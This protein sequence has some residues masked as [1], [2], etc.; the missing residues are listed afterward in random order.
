MISI[1]TFNGEVPRA[2][3]HLLPDNAAQSATDCDF[4]TV[5]LTG[6]PDYVFRQTTAAT[7][8]KSAFCYANSD[9]G[10][11]NVRY[12][13]WQQDA[14]VVRGPVADDAYDRMYW[15]AAPDYRIKVTRDSTLGSSS[16]PDPAKTYWAGVPAPEFAPTANT[17]SMTYGGSSVTDVVAICETATG[18]VLSSTSI[19]STAYNATYLTESA[20]EISLSFDYSALCRV[21]PSGGIGAG[22]SLPT[23]MVLSGVSPTY[24]A[25]PTYNGLVTTYEQIGV[26][27]TSTPVNTYATSGTPIPL[28]TYKKGG[29]DFVRYDDWL[30]APLGNTLYVPTT[31]EYRVQTGQEYGPY[32]GDNG[33]GYAPTYGQATLVTGFKTLYDIG[34]G[35]YATD[36][37]AVSP[38]GLSSAA[39]LAI[40]VYFGSNVITLREN[41]TRSTFGLSGYTGYFQYSPGKLSIFINATGSS[42]MVEQRV[43]AYTYVN[44]FGEEGPL[45]PPLEL[46]VNEGH[47][48]AVTVQGLAAT[49]YAPINK[50]RLYRSATG[51]TTTTLLFVEEFENAVS[52]TYTD[53]KPAAV[54]GEENRT[55]TYF[56][57]EADLRGLIA[58]PNG[59]L[60][61]FK[62]NEVHVSEP[63]LPFA[64]NPENIIPT[65]ETVVSVCAAEGGFYITT[66]GHPYFVSGV[67]PDAMSS[68]KLDAVQAG[69]SKGS[70][71]NIGPAV[72]WASNDGIVFARGG[73]ASMD[74]SFN[75]FT[76]KV[77]RDLYEQRLH[78]M[79]FSAH[80][81]HLVVW[82]EDGYPGFLVK[83]DETQPSM[84]KLLRGFY[85]AAVDPRR[86][87]LLVSLNG[88]D[89]HGF[90]AGSGSAFVWH[91]KDFVAPKP[92]N[93]GAVQIVGDGAATVHCYADGVLRQSKTVTFDKK[94]TVYRLPSGFLARRWSFKIEGSGVI[95]EFNAAISPGEFAGV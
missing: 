64:W 55:S 92:T 7:S 18:T 29:V 73:S 25:V 81:G 40:Q 16:E 36:A 11:L 27:S 41:A 48:V 83:F 54:L 57:P 13:A 76:R 45:S 93:L 87:E 21:R 20:S 91:S 89:L 47:S 12:Y 80:D 30:D 4:T 6:L 60:V 85:A 62:G 43:Y 95:D 49:D 68:I 44:I 56:P 37:S 32:G 15:T 8:I 66:L 19:L 51:S 50:I 79:R 17:T 59:I 38:G 82:F 86:D 63:Y 39:T 46:P 35:W 53:S 65:Q 10:P 71:C 31:G 74:W 23:D 69:V 14:D 58:L 94:G 9:N 42:T 2:Q 75:F 24:A 5:S 3:P 72:L 34:G 61:A 84:T 22:S 77:W 67:T 90:K 78:L 1:K 88:R 26:V 33:F 28:V 70:I 52:V